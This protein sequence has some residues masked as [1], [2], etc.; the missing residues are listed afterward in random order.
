MGVTRLRMST[1]LPVPVERVLEGA[2]ELHAAHPLKRVL[3]IGVYEKDGEHVFASSDPDAGVMLWD[4]E[5]LR[6]ELMKRADV[7]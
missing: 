7:P 2:V 3:V 1:T 6:H 4:M 5:R